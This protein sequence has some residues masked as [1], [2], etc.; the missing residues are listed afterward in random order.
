MNKSAV[1]LECFEDGGE[2]SGVATTLSV[3]LFIFFTVFPF[4][5]SDF[6]RIRFSSISLTHTYTNYFLVPVYFH[7]KIF[8]TFH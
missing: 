8:L 1:S 4:D 6:L 2:I 3:G 5:L 7:H